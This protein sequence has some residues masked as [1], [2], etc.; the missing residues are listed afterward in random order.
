MQQS[1]S[2][3]LFHQNKVRRHWDEGRELW[4]FSIVDVVQ[5]FG[6]GAYRENKKIRL[7][8][9]LEHWKKGKQYDRLGIDTETIK[10]FNTEIAK[11]TIP[12]LPGRNVA[13]LVESAAMNQKLKYL[14]YNAAFELTQAVSLRA[15]GKRKDDEDDEDY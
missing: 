12:I 15:A 3:A 4:Y 14:G 8:V 1:Q 7:V 5:M 9:E 6:A 2:I 10:I 11:I 13:T